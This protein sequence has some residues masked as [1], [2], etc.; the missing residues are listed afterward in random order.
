MN[1]R[2]EK[3]TWIHFGARKFVIG[4]RHVWTN[5]HIIL[6]AQAVPKL[7]TVFD[8]DAVTNNH[9]IL[10]KNMGANITVAP[11]PSFRQDHNELPD[12]GTFTN[13]C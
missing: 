6:H 1:N 5:E 7:N 13:L 11:N 3:G 2:L 4:K 12:C 8:G 10:N 9:I